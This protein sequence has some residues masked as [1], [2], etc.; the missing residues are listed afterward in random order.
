MRNIVIPGFDRL[1]SFGLKLFSNRNVMLYY[2]TLRGQCV[3]DFGA[4]SAFSNT[5]IFRSFEHVLKAFLCISS[6]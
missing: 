6:R 1:E 5:Y 3:Y 2:M 4:D